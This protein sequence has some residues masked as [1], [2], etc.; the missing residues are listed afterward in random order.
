[1]CDCKS[2]EIGALERD[3]S[4]IWKPTGS[5]SREGT[6]ECIN[7]RE[8]LFA[9]LDTP[10]IAESTRKSN[11][12]PADLLSGKMSI[13]LVLPPEKTRSH[14]GLLR[15]WISTLLREC[16]KGG[17]QEQNKIV[18]VL[19]EAASLEH[20][21]CIDD[22]VYQYRG[23]GVR[24]VFVYQNLSQI[25]TCFPDNRDQTLLANVSQMYFGINDF[26]SA[27][28]VSNAIGDGTVITDSGGRNLG[29]SVSNSPQGATT[30]SSWGRNDNWGTTGRKLIQPAE[31]M[32]L[33]PRTAVTLVP[34][35]PP[36]VTRLVRL[37]EQTP[38]RNAGMI[39]K[40][41]G[42]FIGTALLAVVLT[43][44]IFKQPA[45]RNSVL[46]R[47]GHGKTQGNVRPGQGRGSR[48]R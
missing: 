41:M 27:E 5:V 6:F 37:Y 7:D 9:W 26:Q 38:Q 11:F 46:E 12:N 22:A 13:F 30:G 4:P 31:L 47:K 29:G 1:M 20:L 44:G 10:A 28:M 3:C 24:L 14:S 16:V 15:C 39:I 36:I 32:R 19:D 43:V 17:L 8:S 48:P 21:P 35:T 23:Y 45:V 42:W 34:G 18:F 2:P 33:S 25:K 40:V